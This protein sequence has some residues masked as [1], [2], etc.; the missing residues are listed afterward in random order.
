VVTTTAPIVTA[1]N[2]PNGARS[3]RVD[4]F[5]LTDI[6]PQDY[7][8][9]PA[10]GDNEAVIDLRYIGVRAV[11]LGG[12]QFGVQFAINTWQPRT[13]PNYPAEFDIYI[14]SDRDGN[15]DY[16]IFNAEQTGFAATGVNLVFVGPLP[17]GPFQAFFFADADF[18]SGN[19]ILTVPANRIGLSLTNPSSWQPF[20]FYV[21]AFDNYFTGNLT[22]FSTDIMTVNPAFP[23][24]TASISPSPVPAGGSSSLT[25]NK[26]AYNDPES[27]SQLG[28]LL[29]YRDAEWGREADVITLDMPSIIVTKTVG[30]EPR[31]LRH[32][33]RDHGHSR[34]D[35]VLLLYRAEHRQHHADHAQLDRLG[36]G[37]HPKQLRLHTI[38]RCQR[39]RHCQRYAHQ[40][41]GQHGRVGGVC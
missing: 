21:L 5:M 26:L 17:N 2:N 24:A 9:L 18:N 1:L 10:R 27:P 20:D 32:H 23:R 25:I 6:N 41:H 31:R 30:T 12:G 16:V 37:R 11:S 4:A 33:H 22:D 29:M 7:I 14:D 19:I 34:H 15:D 8:T 36:P 38:T 35:G 39:V 3:G 40:H 28:V 13:H